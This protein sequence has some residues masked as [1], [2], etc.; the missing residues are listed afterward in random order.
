MHKAEAPED[1][2]EIA[3]LLPVALLARVKCTPSGL[4]GIC[5]TIDPETRRNVSVFAATPLSTSI[6]F[7][8]CVHVVQL[9]KL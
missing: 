1:R 3:A 5:G 7:C 9:K 6:C 4:L 8:G 2:C